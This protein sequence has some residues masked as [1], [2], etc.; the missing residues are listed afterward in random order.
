MEFQENTGYEKS[1]RYKDRN[2]MTI[3][4][5]TSMHVR[6]GE[7]ILMIISRLKYSNEHFAYNNHHDYAGLNK[8]ANINDNFFQTF[9]KKRN[10]TSV[11]FCFWISIIFSI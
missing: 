1:K 7:H 4:I 11:F 8:N 10:I 6:K 2:S 9:P 3:K 5:M